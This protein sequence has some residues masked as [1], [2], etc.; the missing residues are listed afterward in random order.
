MFSPSGSLYVSR[1]NRCSFGSIAGCAT[2]LIATTIAETKETKSSDKP[3]QGTRCRT[4]GAGETVY[5]R[6]QRSM[7]IVCNFQDQLVEALSFKCVLQH[8]HLVQYTSQCPDVTLAVISMKTILC[9]Q[10]NSCQEQWGKVTI[11]AARLPLYRRAL[12]V[13]A[14]L[15][16]YLPGSQEWC[17]EE[18]FPQSYLLYARSAI[19][20]E[21]PEG[22]AQMPCGV[23]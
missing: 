18:A 3:K 20:G 9:R 21:M 2:Q 8:S 10:Q 15:P 4:E 5:I 17:R 11:V 19:C 23:V 12:I 16:L 7:V 13:P 14:R 22:A 1:W 6:W